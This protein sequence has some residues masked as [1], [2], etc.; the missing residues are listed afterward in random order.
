[1]VTR[2]KAR[3]L[4][5]SVTPQLATL[6]DKPPSSGRWAYEIKLDGYRILARCEHGAVRMFTRSGN[7][8]TDKM[9]SLARELASIPVDSAWF[10]GEIVV[11]QANGLPDF[12]ALQNAFDAKQGSDAMTYF[13]FDA[14]WLDGSDLRSMPFSERR[15]VL[16]TVLGRHEQE[17][18]RLSATF[19]ADGASVLQS[20]CKMG[21]EGIIAKRL[22]A[23]YKG[24][25]DES[26]LK[27]KCQRRQEFVI[28]GFVTRTGSGREIGSLLLGVYDD[29][30]R[31]RYA[32]SVGTGWDATLAAA[33]LRQ[34]ERIETNTMP[35][36]SEF[37]PKKGRW[38]KRAV[39]GER[40]VAPTTMCEVT[41]TEWTPDGHIRHPS[42]KGMRKDK[43]A[44][45]VRRE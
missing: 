34:L 42:F 3:T 35:F 21:L 4:P 43:P 8:W 39:G 16:E 17:R 9:S 20:A 11:Q 23:S 45:A 22:D 32:G 37:P 30:G 1:M 41:F 25:R 26:W 5:A 10:D 31:L 38:S 28:G 27:I 40:W 2:R 19:D 12:N 6:V 36:D 33:I 18:V 7:D 15:E 44:T 24:T 13:V 29:A 14:L